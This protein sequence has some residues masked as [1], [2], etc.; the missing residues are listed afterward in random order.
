MGY[1]FSVQYKQGKENLCADALSRLHEVAHATLHSITTLQSDTLQHIRESWK[2]DTHLQQI[3]AAKEAGTA[4]HR[5]YSWEHGVLKRK[6]KLVIGDDQGL[7]QRLFQMYHAGSMGGHS[8]ISAIYQR[9]K[10]LSFL[11][12]MKPEIYNYIQQ[13][14]VCQQSKSDNQWPM[15]L[16]QPLP[17]PDHIWRDIS[18]DGLLKSLGKSTI[19]V[20]V[21]HL[22][23]QAHFMA[24]PHPYTA[25]TVA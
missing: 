11:K 8:G 20:V 15:G 2:G 16:L 7:K 19:F 21:D 3:I 5:K 22:S 4:A 17:I 1:N 18:L 10:R 25:V 23:K 9:M 14:T 6:G 24:M 13:F 12:K